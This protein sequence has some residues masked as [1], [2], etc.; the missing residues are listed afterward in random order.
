VQAHRLPLR[1]GLFW[2]WGGWRLY[3]RNPPLV[4]A[5]TM[6]YLFV[7]VLSLALTGPIGSLVVPVLLPLLTLLLGNGLQAAQQRKRL[8]S[9]ML[10]FGLTGHPGTW[11]ILI[12]LGLLQLIGALLLGSVHVQLQNWGILPV[13]TSPPRLADLWPT[14]LVILALSAP[15]FMAFTFAP[16]LAGWQHIQAV[17]AVFFSFVACWRNIGAI[18]VWL[19]SALCVGALIPSLLL[20]AI[21]SINAG[22]GDALALV[23]NILLLFLM[24][25]VFSASVL[26]AYRDIFEYTAPAYPSAE[27]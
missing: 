7:I 23:V 14:L 11:A 22:F 26:M 9:E 5:L 20:G 6:A 19:G 3:R 2:L 27:S 8:E 1:H 24:A 17:Q 25:P 21:A 15:L 18:A 13:W 10:L 16:Y 12:R 4:L